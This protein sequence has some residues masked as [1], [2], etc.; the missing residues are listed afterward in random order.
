MTLFEFLMALA[1]GLT[2]LVTDEL[3]NVKSAASPY[4]T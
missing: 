4:S 1:S 3:T 2:P